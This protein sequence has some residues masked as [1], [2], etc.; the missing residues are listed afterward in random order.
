ML[1]LPSAQGSLPTCW[2]VL[3]SGRFRTDWTTYWISRRHG[4]LLFHQVNIAW[5]HLHSAVKTCAFSGRRSQNPDQNRSLARLSFAS[6]R[7]GTSTRNAI[8][9]SEQ[10]SPDPCSP[11]VRQRPHTSRM[12]DVG[13][14]V[15]DI[16]SRERGKTRQMYVAQG[17][18]TRMEVLLTPRS[19]VRSLLQTHLSSAHESAKQPRG[20][21]HRSS[22]ECTLSCPTKRHLERF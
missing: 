18:A 3:W 21:R 1:L 9:A 10:H 7:E 14:D 4:H 8:R 17:P 19:P 20:K 22:A 2:A 6:C 16:P 13:H 5:S 12:I 15:N 11:P